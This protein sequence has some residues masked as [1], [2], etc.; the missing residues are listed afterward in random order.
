MKVLALHL[1]VSTEKPEFPLCAFQCSKTD[2]LVR[3]KEHV[4]YREVES[5]LLNHPV[6][7][8]MIAEMIFIVVQCLAMFLINLIYKLIIIE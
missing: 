4:L 7:L 1:C 8:L 5:I 6:C 3:D 2:R